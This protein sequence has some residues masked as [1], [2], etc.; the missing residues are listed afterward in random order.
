[1]VFF[2]E[3]TSSA[4]RESQR[5]GVSGPFAEGDIQWHDSSAFS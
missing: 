4:A 5:I 1:M 2:F 3:S